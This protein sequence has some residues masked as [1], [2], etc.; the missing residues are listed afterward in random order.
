MPVET[1]ACNGQAVR[2]VATAALVGAILRGIV[3]FENQTPPLYCVDGGVEGIVINVEL[4]STESTE[5]AKHLDEHR[6]AEADVLRGRKI[7][8]VLEPKSRFERSQVDEIACLSPAKDGQYLVDSQLLNAEDEAQF[9]PFRWQET[10]VGGDVDARALHTI[11]DDQPSEAGNHLNLD[12][13]QAGGSDS[14]LEDRHQLIDLRWID[15]E[16][17]EV[18]RPTV[19]LTV[20]NQRRSA[21]ENK[22]RRFRELSQE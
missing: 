9:A 21:G 15:G 13:S 2:S 18:T 20:R 11:G 7:A 19:N 1:L 12:D 14:G 5:P 17:V 10:S 3:A 16:E 6:L 22:V 4:I 8:E